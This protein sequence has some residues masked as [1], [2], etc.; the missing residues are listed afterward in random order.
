MA[1]A[2]MGKGESVWLG[3]FLLKA[4]GDFTSIARERED[5]AHAQKWEAH[6]KAL[7]KALE[8]SAWDG[9]WYRR[10]SYDDGSPARIAQIRRMLDRFDR[11]IL[12]RAGGRRSEAVRTERW[13][14]AF[15]RLVD[16]ELDIVK[17]F[18]PAFSKTAIRN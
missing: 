15:E 5:E 1:S 18:T 10:G 6:E 9:A 12:E 11:P 17:L 7:K 8:H 14:P 16:P 13:S 3:W 2:L 4:L